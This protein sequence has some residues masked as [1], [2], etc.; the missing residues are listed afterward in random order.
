MGGDDQPGRPSLRAA[1]RWLAP[2]LLV[3]V[4][5]APA[6]AA[7]DGG[8]DASVDLSGADAA[9]GAL[10]GAADAGD[11]SPPIAAPGAQPSLPPTAEP[12]GVAFRGRVLE[13]GSKHPLA[14][15]AIKVDNTPAATT[16]ADGRFE[17][18]VA[19]G[20][21]R[22]EI[23]LAG[24]ATLHV[25]VDAPAELPE[26]T[27]RM[28]PGLAGEHHETVVHAGRPE[29]AKITLSGDEARQTAGT[30]GDPM[31]LIGAL[32]GVIQI[33][34]P[35]A[36]YVV[37]GANPGNTGFFL[38]GIRVPALFHLAL[39]P[40]VIHLYLIDGVDFYPGG[41]PANYGPYVSGIM[42]ART[43][44]P[45]ADRVHASVDVTFFDAGGIVTSPWDGGRGTVAVAGRYSYTEKFSRCC[46]PARRSVMATTSCGPTTRSPAARRPCSRS[47]RSTAWAGPT[48]ARRRSSTD[49][50]SSTAWICAG[51]ARSGAGACSSAPRS[52]P[53]GRNRRC[54]APPSRSGP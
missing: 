6:E 5:G 13:R 2:A 53:I 48:S 12:P 36:L 50:C 44:A 21:H 35:A 16:D 34:W 31:R 7:P 11:A 26:Q 17:L 37:R 28:T 32:P 27:F 41:Y 30:S 29:L 14:G 23:Q 24:E 52:A 9:P 39:G 4:V 1:A 40:S 49:R 18:S 54:S 8:A 20:A 45:P 19:P 33:A 47:D 25:R 3:A 38:D 42:T 15:A 43:V 46:R 51:V 22:L 10:D